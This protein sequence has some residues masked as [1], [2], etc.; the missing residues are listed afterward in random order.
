[1]PAP[2]SRAPLRSALR[3]CEAAAAAAPAKSSEL[4]LDSSACVLHLL[5]QL[6]QAADGGSTVCGLA[7]LA[8]GGSGEGEVE[9]HEGEYNTDHGIDGLRFQIFPSPPS[10]PTSRRIALVPSNP[11]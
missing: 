11:N 7:G 4:G 1:M 8:A 10:R 2:P 9:E 6:L 3:H 5:R